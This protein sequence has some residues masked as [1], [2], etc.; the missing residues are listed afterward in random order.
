[1]QPMKKRSRK[2]DTIYKPV[3]VYEGERYVENVIYDCKGCRS[4]L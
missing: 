2:K 3:M 1:M 4:R